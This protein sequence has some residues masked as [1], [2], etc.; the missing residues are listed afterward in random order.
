MSKA[1]PNF[2]V[3]WYNGGTRMFRKG[4][5]DEKKARSFYEEKV[6]SSST[7]H[8]TLKSTKGTLKTW[9]R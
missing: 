6:K 4:F 8:V 7:D 5:D 1:Y 2:T 9:N 3:L